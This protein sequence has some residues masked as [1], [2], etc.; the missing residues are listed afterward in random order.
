[1]VIFHSFLYKSPFSSWVNPLFRLGHGFKFANCKRLELGRV[2]GMTWPKAKMGRNFSQSVEKWCLPALNG[3]KLL[4]KSGSL[5]K[6]NTAW[7][8]VVSTPLKNISQLETY[9][10]EIWC[11]YHPNM[12][13]ISS[14]WWLSPTPLKKM[15][16][17]RLGLWNSQYMEKW[18]MIQTTNQNSN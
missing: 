15:S 16:E 13:W 12:I 4:Q 1:M 5:G 2:P 3:K 10:L 11:E 18:K 8:L 9:H 17:P 7:W 6:R 14:G